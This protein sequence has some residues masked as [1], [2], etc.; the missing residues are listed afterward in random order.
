MSGALSAAESSQTYSTPSGLPF[1]IDRLRLIGEGG[2]PVEGSDGG[3]SSVSSMTFSISLGTAESVAAGSSAAG[4]A[5]VSADG[6]GVSA[7]GGAGVSAEGC[8][9]SF[10]GR[11]GRLSRRCRGLSGR[12]RW[13]L[14]RRRWCRFRRR[15]RCL[16]R[17][18]GWCSLGRLLGGSCR[19]GRRGTLRQWCR[20]VG[21]HPQK[22]DHI[23]ALLGVGDAGE[24]HHRSRRE[25]L[26]IL[27]PG[28]EQSHTSTR[29]HAPSARACS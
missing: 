13:C 9:C 10:R 3:L 17:W 7:A 23:G 28:I 5:G 16:G 27:Q 29:P 1:R 18:C 15:R 25:G 14:S 11:C 6:A 12:R 2:S 19:R 8:R 21:V 20:G 26:R 24:S 22:G 4:G